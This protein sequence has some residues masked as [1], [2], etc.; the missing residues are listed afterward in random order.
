MMKGRF[1]L[2]LMG[3]LGL[4]AHGSSASYFETEPNNTFPPSFLPS[5]PLFNSGD[6][7]FGQLL[8]ANDVD[9]F[10]VRFA[11]VATPGIY[12]YR[13]DL[14]AGGLDTV[15]ELFD[16]QNPRFTLSFSDDYRNLEPICV[17]EQLETVPQIRTWG[18]MAK[19][20]AG[21]LVFSYNLTM[22]REL[23]TPVDLGG[24]GDGTTSR[25]GVSPVGGLSNWYTFT[26]PEES[27]VT[28]DTIGNLGNIDTELVLFDANGVTVAANDDIDRGLS[29]LFSKI[30]RHLPAGTYYT[31]VSRYNVAHNWNEATN[32][33]AEWDRHGIG[34][35]NEVATAT[36][37]FTIN[38]AV[39]STE[40]EVLSYSVIKGFEVTGGLSAL[41]ASDDVSVVVYPDN[42]FAA[43]IQFFG[44]GIF[45]AVSQLRMQVEAGVG[46]PGLSQSI[47]MLNFQTNAWDELDGRL[48]PT[49][50]LL[51]EIVL[52]GSANAHLGNAGEMF[53]RIQWSPVNDEDPALDG[54]EHRLDL[55]KWIAV[56]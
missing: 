1:V 13:F 46:R 16:A 39:R 12:R 54:W 28:I 56:P 11:P 43:G 10:Y 6:G 37:L 29:N 32:T 42:E 20:F 4:A 5:N 48:A 33:L 38:I 36:A 34:V 31:A 44:D 2:A 50:D 8:P 14:A 21:S 3:V 49:D 26:L 41:K 19:H 51:I 27:D 22:T 15:M 53:G 25:I 18:I 23:V 47:Q 40:S 24:L 7:I 9:Y 30:Q 35:M 45:N 17:F 55:A 52:T